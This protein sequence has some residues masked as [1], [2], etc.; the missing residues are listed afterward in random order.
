[1]WPRSAKPIHSS[2][3]CNVPGQPES[4]DR[5]FARLLLQ[6]RARIPTPTSDHWSL[7]ATTP[8]TCCKRRPP[9][10]GGSSTRFG[11]NSNFLAWCAPGGASKCSTFASGG[12][13]DVLQFSD[14]FLDAVADETVSESTQLAD[15]QELLDECMDKLPAARPRPSDSRYRSDLP[16][17]TL[18]AHWAGRFRRPTTR[19]PEPHPPH[20]GGMCPAGPQP[21][22]LGR[23]LNC[24]PTDE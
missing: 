3:G 8:K 18:A 22:R 16:V 7:T 2:V 20:A 1:M 5:G 6:Y 11:R 12:K 24:R 19:P 10:S 15:L 4:G 13:R 14:L 23:K 17:K 21:G 9:C